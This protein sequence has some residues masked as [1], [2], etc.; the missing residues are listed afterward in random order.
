VT[1]TP[2]LDAYFQ[3]L[4][5][6]G[7]RDP[8]LETLKRLVAAHG[9]VLPFE[10]LDVLLGR[11]ISIEPQ[12]I[13]NKLVRER[14]GGYCFEQNT[15][16]LH[17]LKALGYC[18]Q[19]LSSRVYNQ[20]PRSNM[21]VRTHLILRVEIEGDSWLADVGVGS[22][23]PTTP[24]RLELN[25]SQPNSHETR[26]IVADGEWRDLSLRAPDGR[27]FHQALL[28]NEW[29]DVAEFTL[30]EM[31]P[32]DRE[33]ANWYTSTHPESKFRNELLVARVTKSGR[34]SLLNRVFTRRDISG[35]AVSRTV[36]TPA[37]LLDVLAAEFG[38]H[39]PHDTRFDCPGLK[40]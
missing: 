35:K 36:A 10:N 33:L 21:P 4:D 3:R 1:F 12:A 24:L 29:V 26:R 13:E 30:E 28:N 7:P 5:D 8:T 16:L 32:V 22:M 6:D 17:V 38:L 2:D 11:G 40:W 27:L 9:R 19:P 37:E 15:L 18:V 23:T 25:T 14:R 31:H 20:L 34:I 39:F